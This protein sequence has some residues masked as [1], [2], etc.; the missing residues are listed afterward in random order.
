M[1]ELMKTK[2]RERL[3]Q[4][5]YENA[6][7]YSKEQIPLSSGINS[8]YYFDIKELAGDPEGINVVSEVLYDMIKQIGEIKS[9]GG[10]EAGSISLSTAISQRSYK[11]DYPLKSF[12]VR[13]EPKPHGRRKWIEGHAE[14]PVVAVEDVTTTGS[15]SLKAVRVLRES[16][17][18]V[19]YL[20]TVIYRDEPANAKEFEKKHD[21]KLLYIFPEKE[22]I[23]KYEKEHPEVLT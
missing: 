6:F 7:Y 10:L 1:M 21:I 15:S 12:F 11:T 4:L 14:S 17:Y 23:E 8:H 16:K 18:D 3:F 9:V 19:R 22:F 13:K 2:Q 20:L 5:I